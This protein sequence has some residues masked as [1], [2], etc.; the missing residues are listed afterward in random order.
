M[1]V[2]IEQSKLIVV[3]NDAVFLFSGSTSFSSFAAD[4]SETFNDIVEN[5]V[6]LTSYQS[7]DML[8]YYI[9]LFLLFHFAAVFLMTFIY[10]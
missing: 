8:T 7:R 4:S 5:S 3:P 9:L 2:T 6:L 10:C 1:H